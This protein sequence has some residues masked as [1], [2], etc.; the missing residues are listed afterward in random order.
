MV[1]LSL[2]S[3]GRES[4]ALLQCQMVSFAICSP[5]G[6]AET[7]ADLYP[8]ERS[9]SWY[10]AKLRIMS[11]SW[12]TVYIS[13]NLSPLNMKPQS[14]SSLSLRS[15]NGKSLTLTRK[16]SWDSWNLAFS[17]VIRSYSL[18]PSSEG[19]LAVPFARSASAMAWVSTILPL[20]KLSFKA[21]G[22]ATTAFL[23]AVTVLFLVVMRVNLPNRFGFLSALACGSSSNCTSDDGS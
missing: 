1:T 11:N 5:T 6:S 7:K 15:W 17:L 21:S 14:K 20:L 13:R 2:F 4:E 12:T 10:A 3:P 23:L 8:L 19:M 18:S 22:V 9:A 16:R